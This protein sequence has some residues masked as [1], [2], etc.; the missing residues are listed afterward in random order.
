LAGIAEAYIQQANNRNILRNFYQTSKES[1]VK[2][3]AEIINR[4]FRDSW[5]TKERKA[6]NTNQ[7]KARKTLIM[8]IGDRGTDV[9]SRVKGFRRYGGH[10]KEGVY[11]LNTP[12]CVTN[13]N[14]TSQTCIFCY[15]KPSHPQAPITLS[16]TRKAKQKIS[17]KK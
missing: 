14:K 9:G 11:G 16:E 5:C 3:K 12:V 7:R 4:S 13:E 6:M 17:R 15:S 2:H 1:H 8:F 10:W